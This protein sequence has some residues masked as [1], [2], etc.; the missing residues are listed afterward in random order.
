MEKV[1]NQISPPTFPDKT[2]VITDY[3]NGKDSLYTDAI[4]RAIEACSSQG[5]GTV[6]VPDG[7]FLTAPIRLKSNVNLHL[8]DSTILKFTTDYNLFETVL[9]RI[10]G[11]DCHNISPLIYAYGE[12]NIAIT[13]KGKLDGQASTDNWFAEQ[14]I[15][16]I[17][18][19]NGETVNEKTLLYQ[20]KEDSIPVKERIF[21]KANGIRP[22][23]INLY[24]CKNIL[25]EGFTINRSPFWLIHPLL[26]ENVT[27]KGVKM[28]SHGPNNDGCDPESC[29]NVLIEDCDF[30]TGDDCIAIKS[31][32]DED[33]RYWNIPC[34][35]IIV[36]E[37]RMKDGHAGV[38]IGSEI[39]GGC[40]NVW[41][42]NCQ[43]DS[44]ELDRIIRIKSNPMR[45]GNVENVFVRNI[46]VGEC[47]QSILG[48][49]QKYWHVDEGPYLP[50]FENI[51]LE[52]I[53]SKK[54]QYVLHLD[55]FDDKSQIRNIYLKDCS[56][57]GVE[58][59]EINKVTGAENIR[60]ENVTVNG[61]PFHEM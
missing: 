33:G 32:R 39:T 41:V 7:E 29:E 47:K 10:E 53:T 3:Y 27:I 54:S 24:K 43:M 12:N 2:Y 16:G 20:M 44:P 35:N 52:N 17:K 55:G 14:R 59:P 23:F 42:E 18:S 26:S 46:T 60:F 50:L 30:D 51:H 31:G 36:R 49:E 13:G 45:G 9:T 37:C 40:H 48:I 8:S 21:E 11:I 15:R 28:Q 25:L 56:F 61:E 38:A 57:E 58:K 19:E 1:Y 22:Q 5:G 4:N 34:K 6:L